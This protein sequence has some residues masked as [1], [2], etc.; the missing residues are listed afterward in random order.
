[1]KNVTSSLSLLIILILLVHVILNASTKT[2]SI[3]SKS[4]RVEAGW[5]LLSVPLNVASVSKDSLFPSAVSSAYIYQNGYEPKDTLQNGIGFWLKF[6]SS[7]TLPLT[8]NIIFDDTIDVYTGWNII[9]SMTVP[10]ATNTLQT[11]PTGIINS[12]AFCYIPGIGYQHADTIQPGIGYWVKVKQDGKIILSSDSVKNIVLEI[13]KVISDVDYVSNLIGISQDSTQYIFK[14]SLDSI[15]HLKIGDIIISTYKEGLIRKITNIQH[16]NDQFILTTTDASLT[17]AIAKGS[18]SFIEYLTTKSIT[19]VKYLIPGVELNELKEQKVHGVNAIS[20]SID[21]VLYD[22]DGDEETEDD[23]ITTTG[24]FEIGPVIRGTIELDRF[25]LKK[26]ELEYEFVERLNQTIDMP[27]LDLEILQFEKTIAQVSFQ[28]FAI[29]VGGIPVIVYPVLLIKVGADISVNSSLTTGIYQ[30]YTFTAGLRYEEN[31]WDTYAEKTYSFDYVPPS[32]ENTLSAKFYLEPDLEFR[33]YG[34]LSPY[35]YGE[36]YGELDA[37]LSADHCWELY[38]GLNLGAGVNMKIFDATIFDFSAPLIELRV[39]FAQAEGPCFNRPPNAPSDPFPTDYATSRPTNDTLSW[40]CSDPDN[41]SLKYDVYF[42]TD[43]PP[44]TEVSSDQTDTSLVRNGLAN[45]TQY[46]WQVI[47][48]DTHGDSTAGPVWNFATY[49][50]GGSPCPGTPT[51]DYA[52]KIYNTVQVG[53]QC[54]LKENLDV[55]TMIVGDSNQTNNSIIEKYCYS[56]NPTNCNTYGGLYQWNEAMQYFITPGAR[57]ICPS[58]WHIPTYAEFQ[59]LSTA[60]GGI[61][62]GGNALKAVGQ[63]T[64][65]GA[66]TNASGFSAL[67]TGFR[68]YGGYFSYLGGYEYFWSSTEPYASSAGIMY[69]A[70]GNSY[71]Y[72]S[73]LPK[74]YGFSVRCV[75]D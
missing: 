21:A 55:G 29:P 63:G 48:K 6:D 66:G 17:D 49:G 45:G 3:T 70:G 32:L 60:V 74:G 11:E 64:G 18:G 54:W 56:N 24:T 30:D 8:G 40:S 16:N 50:G 57:G 61:L 67:L 36:L 4:I 46:Y 31:T 23:Q 37:D 59:T 22:E 27:V 42:G 47:A 9:G 19:S 13:T 12:E 52:G 38:G 53:N 14:S 7:E 26:L 34:I 1:M 43:N 58:G 39:N 73:Y 75:K 71:I 65:A 15:Y 20:F 33:I 25:D 2:E 44:V 28:P 10:I 69:L 62:V 51:V 35:L 5:N 68:A 72:H 41:D